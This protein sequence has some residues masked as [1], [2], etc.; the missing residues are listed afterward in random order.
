MGFPEYYQ[1]SLLSTEPGVAPEHEGLWP[2]LAPYLSER[3]QWVRSDYVGKG[4][5]GEGKGKEGA[6]AADQ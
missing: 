4:K 3:A 6:S 1:G 2:P 5:R